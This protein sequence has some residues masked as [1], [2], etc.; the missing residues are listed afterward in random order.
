V[1][2]CK[3]HSDASPAHSRADH[4]SGLEW[5]LAVLLTVY[6]A[7]GA[8]FAS[9][10]PIL[11][12]LAFRKPK[13]VILSEAEKARKEREALRK[14]QEEE[15]EQTMMEDRIKEEEKRKKKEA[16][17]AEARAKAEAAKKESSAASDY[18]KTI[19]EKKAAA[20]KEPDAGEGVVMLRVRCP[21]GTQLTR[22]FSVSGPV[23]DLYDYVDIAR[24]DKAQ[25][26]AKP[27][28]R[29]YPLWFCLRARP[30]RR[31]HLHYSQYPNSTFTQFSLRPLSP[32]P[33]ISCTQSPF[34]QYLLY[35]IPLSLYPPLSQRL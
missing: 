2:P 1:K 11:K 23:S 19:E 4:Q 12:D 6:A 28:V 31:R 18:T 25:N 5:L 26:T 34:S 17:E 30:G 20:G 21:D 29:L 22:K 8:P 35:S 13:P 24:F 15:F 33:N 3:F 14:E 32:S 7:I 9:Y 16:A 27:E 10:I